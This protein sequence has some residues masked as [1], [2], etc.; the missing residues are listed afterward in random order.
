[1][2]E[3][4]IAPCGMNCGVCEQYLARANSL[5]DKGFQVQYCPGC[6]PSGEHCPAMGKQCERLGKGLVRFCYECDDYPCSNLKGLDKRYRTEY[7]L[8][9][10]GNLE[11]IKEYGLAAFLEKEAARWRCPECG[12]VISCH[13]G[14]CLGCD[15]DKLSYAKTGNTGGENSE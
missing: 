9:Q 1:M 6:L 7:H 5:K 15:L 8:S 11:F 12:G 2:N 10:I 4:L 14:L 3:D 13:N